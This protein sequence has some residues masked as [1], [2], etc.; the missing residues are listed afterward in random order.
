M[1]SAPKKGKG[2]QEKEFVEKKAAD[3]INTLV[4]PSSEPVVGADWTP[5]NRLVLQQ[6]TTY[7]E[8]EVEAGIVSNEAKDSF[9]AGI[10]EDVESDNGEAN[11]IQ[12][13]ADELARLQST[14]RD[15]KEAIQRQAIK[16]VVVGKDKGG[17]TDGKINSQVPTLAAGRYT[18][19]RR[20]Q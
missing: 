11:R 18:Q 14:A 1:P 13:E 15:Y 2:A 3:T 10:S 12:R 16:E 7:L 8:L 6:H 20:R 9:L 17:G 5:H 4:P 19:I